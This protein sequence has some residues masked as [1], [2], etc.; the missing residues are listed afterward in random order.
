[1]GT[2]EVVSQKWQAINLTCWVR[3]Q[4]YDGT[5]NKGGLGL[6]C[7]NW[8]KERTGKAKGIITNPNS[9]GISAEKIAFEKIYFGKLCHLAICW[10]L[11]VK[12]TTLY[13]HIKSKCITAPLSTFYQYWFNGK[14]WKSV[15]EVNREAEHKEWAVATFS[16]QRARSECFSHF[17]NLWLRVL[18]ILHPSACD[19]EINLSMPRWRMSHFFK[20]TCRRE[21]RGGL[22]EEM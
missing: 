14:L 5:S 22:S 12:Q 19:P 10:C 4:F 11:F 18:S 3:A 7:W 20:C 17:S 21:E 13:C 16:M 2:S 1:M 9:V 15:D 6:W 8:K